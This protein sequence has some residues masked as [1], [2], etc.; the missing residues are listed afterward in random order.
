MSRGR[1]IAHGGGPRCQIAGCGKGAQRGGIC[2]A[3]GGG[4][5]CQVAGC[6]KGAKGGQNCMTGGKHYM[7]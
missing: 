1:C 7:T 3:H 4:R 2:I 6:N 5:R